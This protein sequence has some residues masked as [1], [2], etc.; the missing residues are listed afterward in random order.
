M[1]DKQKALEELKGRAGEEFATVSLDIEKGLIKKFAE[2][3]G[4][5][6]PLWCDES[7]SGGIIAPP[8]LMMTI[9]FN[10]I[11]ESLS[12]D[13]LLTVLHGSTELE[14]KKEVH[15]GD[16]ITARAKITNIRERKGQMGSTLFVYIDVDLLNQKD[17]QVAACRQMAIVY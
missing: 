10:N 15:P 13:S 4:D 6:N 14:A 2:A 17:E 7:R 12:Y 11:I 3:V 8:T 5:E 1:R 16:K 9:G